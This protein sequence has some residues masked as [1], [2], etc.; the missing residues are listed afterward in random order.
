[1][2]P[3]VASEPGGWGS[4][5]SDLVLPDVGPEAEGGE[6]PTLDWVFSG[7]ASGLAEK[8]KIPL[9]PV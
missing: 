1:M 4:T 8:G 7:V 3:D 9:E 6:N 5:P 2:F